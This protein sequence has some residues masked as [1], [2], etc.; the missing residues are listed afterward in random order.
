MLIYEQA[1]ISGGWAF[2]SI[3]LGCGCILGAGTF[4]HVLTCAAPCV[5]CMFNNPFI[6]FSHILFFPFANLFFSFFLPTSLPFSVMLTVVFCC[7]NCIS[8]L[9]SS[10]RILL[11]IFFLS[12]FAPY[13]LVRMCPSV[14]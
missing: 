3:F 1:S 5:Y 10:V 13:S 8:V 14:Y 11:D 4:V 7:C 6:S 12:S 2:T 9:Y